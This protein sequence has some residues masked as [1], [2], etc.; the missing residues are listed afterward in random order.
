MKHFYQVDEP[1][2]NPLYKTGDVVR[3]KKEFKKIGGNLYP[4]EQ[5]IILESYTSQL[6]NRDP[7]MMTYVLLAGDTQI[8]LYEHCL[9]S[10]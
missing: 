7:I 2:A 3:F 6:E 4:G 1:D 9:E 10:S 5:M 8:H